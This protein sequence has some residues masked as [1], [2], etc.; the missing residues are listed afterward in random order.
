MSCLAHRVTQSVTQQGRQDQGR[1]ASP[2]ASAGVGAAQL[3][4]AQLIQTLARG[5]QRAPAWLCKPCDSYCDTE[6]A[7]DKPLRSTGHPK[8]WFGM[9]VTIL[10]DGIS[11]KT[12]HSLFTWIRRTL[13]LN[14]CLISKTRVTA[15]TPQL[16]PQAALSTVITPDC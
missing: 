8:G 9:F 4:R 3:G 16:L 2:G 6:T 14:N 12:K 1:K 13:Q 7:L 15:T 10:E 5:T 11:L